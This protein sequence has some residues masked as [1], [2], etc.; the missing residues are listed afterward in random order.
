[1]KRGMHLVRGI[2][3]QGSFAAK[4]APPGLRFASV[5]AKGEIKKL[6]V[7]AKNKRQMLLKAGFIGLFLICLIGFAWR[8]GRTEKTELLSNE[9]RTFEKARVVSILEDN[10][11]SEGTRAGYQTV[12]V[13]ILTG[14]HKGE[15]L[16][17]T[18]SSSYLYGA[19]CTVGLRVIVIISE[20][21]DYRT[22]SV[23]N[24]DRGNQLYAIILFF[25][26]VLGLIGG[27]KGWKSGLGLVFTFA[28]IIF[29]FIPMV[30][31]GY[32][33]IQS[34][35]FLVVLVTVVSM[36]LIDG[37]TVKAICAMAGTILG[38][39]I[40]A[41]CAE[42]FGR[43]A[44]LSGYNVSD[45]EDLI[46]IGEMTDIR[47]GELMFAGILISALGAVMDVAMSVA[48]TV[49]EI[50]EKTPSLSRKELFLSGIH[51][52]RDMM[53]TCPTP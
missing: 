14:E 5:G 16:E 15:T 13:E 33:P 26:V 2:T 32:S 36:L 23:Y 12:E 8:L 49:N 40:A 28:C 4:A 22:V 7:Q 44:H 20:S 39:C 42:L 6:M 47:I 27:R 45:I 29:L 25:L 17:A 21:S 52:G 31:R 1:M 48:S 41:V 51:V 34:A 50:H 53:G 30:Y 37:W 3:W 38:V 19:N 43:F 35:A 10:L 11:T 46:Y 9:G 24:Y 18:S